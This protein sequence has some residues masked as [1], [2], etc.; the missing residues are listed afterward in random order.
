MDKKL[1]TDTDKE[2]LELIKSEAEKNLS[3]IH[4]TED[5]ITNKSSNLLKTVIS[6]FIITSGYSIRAF[7]L[8]QYDYLF[9]FSISL[10]ILFIV[11]ISILLFVIFPKD[12][13]CLG[14]EPIK[15]VTPN[16][17]KGDKYDQYRILCNKIEN[18][19]IAIEDSLSS[20]RTRL[21]AY[22]Q[23]NQILISGVI[24]I[25]LS[26]SLFYLFLNVCLCQ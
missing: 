4:A 16:F 1:L 25:F 20:Y 10:S 18:L 19:Q 6:F 3:N 13:V 14:S 26:I 15:I 22:K 17:I 9:S 12:T 2:T 21:K 5:V 7:S 11:I 23:S 24:L 8:S